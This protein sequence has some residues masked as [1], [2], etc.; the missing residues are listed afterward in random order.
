MS[1][2]SNYLENALLRHLFGLASYTP[3]TIYLGLFTAAPDDAG[4]G[5]EVAGNGYARRPFGTASV[6]GT[7]PTEATN[8]DLIEFAAATAAWGAITHAGLFDAATAGNL[9]L[10]F[11]LVD[12]DDF[13][14]PLSKTVS[15][16]DVF[17]IAAG[18]LKVRAN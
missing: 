8:A 5:T 12:P 4:G 6:A 1:N 9:L 14:T 16:G 3:P 10:W 15:K 18:Q 7:A 17:R 11:P 13:V 2:A